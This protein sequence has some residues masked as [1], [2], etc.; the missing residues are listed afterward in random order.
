MIYPGA[1]FSYHRNKLCGK[2]YRLYRCIKSSIIFLL[3]YPVLSRSQLNDCPS[4][5]AVH[6]CCGGS[7]TRRR[8]SQRQKLLILWTVTC[9]KILKLL[10]DRKA[11]NRLHFTSRKHELRLHLDGIQIRENRQSIYILQIQYSGYM[12]ISLRRYDHYITSCSLS[13]SIK[14]DPIT[15]HI[16]MA[17]Q[18]KAGTQR[19]FTDLYSNAVA[20]NEARNFDEWN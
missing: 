19:S 11:L 13:P 12:N 15:S 18:R 17:L 6:F 7:C 16:H 20:R 10:H 9:H 8:S 3:K 14:Y 2:A 1:K 5:N 4:P